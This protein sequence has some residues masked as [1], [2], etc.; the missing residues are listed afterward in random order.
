MTL[1]INRR[2][3]LWPAAYCWIVPLMTIIVRILG[4][5]EARLLIW[6]SHRWRWYVPLRSFWL[7]VLCVVRFWA[8]I[9]DEVHGVVV[10]LASFLV[11]I[12]FELLYKF[13]VIN[14]GVV[15]LTSLN[16]TWLIFDL[17]LLLLSLF[18]NEPSIHTLRRLGQF[19]SARAKTQPRA[20]CPI[21]KLV[22]IGLHFLFKSQID[23]HIL[24]FPATFVRCIHQVFDWDFV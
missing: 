9:L 21:L 16:E 23:W 12:V 22:N 19:S 20:L 17:F 3:S 2:S 6:W 13:V 4:C 24:R 7:F 1:C 11:L 5:Q 10:R 15:A 8:V 14:S 18:L